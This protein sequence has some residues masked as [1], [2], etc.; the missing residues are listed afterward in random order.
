MGE[1]AGAR[2]FDPQAYLDRFLFRRHVDHVTL[3]PS[4]PLLRTLHQA[5]LFAVPFENLSIHSGEPI[6][7]EEAA[8]YDKIVRRHRGGFC[9]ELNGLFAWLLRQ[10]GFTVW[11]LSARVAQADGGFS[12]EFDH[13]T[14]QVHSLDGA[15][16]LA[17]VGFGDSFR[18]PLRLQP[19]LEQDGGDGYTY[20]LRVDAAAT[21]EE[22][23]ASDGGEAR[24]ASWLLQRRGA[25]EWT[26]WEAQYRFASRP[27]VMADF[28]ERCLFQQTSPDSHFTQRRVC[29]L[30]LPDGRVTLSDRRLITTLHGA[31]EE[32]ELASEEEYRAVLA[33]RFGVTL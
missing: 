2:L 3:Q 5:H 25:T 4:V 11:L 10:L 13:L 14:L 23:D 17:D 6:S 22:G 26:E 33:D 29:S 28:V 21:G 20:R 31:R 7:L 19:D 32:R 8:L 1:S 16:W 27:H 18:L 9:Y 24:A 15:E 12:P 30:A